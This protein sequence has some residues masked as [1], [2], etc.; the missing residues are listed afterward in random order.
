MSVFDASGLYFCGRN[1]N[2]S[3]IIRYEGRKKE[4]VESLKNEI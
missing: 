3:I 4:G 2:H 1:Y